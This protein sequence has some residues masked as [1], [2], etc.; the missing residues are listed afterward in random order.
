L[1]NGADVNIKD[2]KGRT[3]FD[4]A[5]EPT[6]NFIAGNFEVVKELEEN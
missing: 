5:K 3:A 2:D 1:D 4:I 6:K